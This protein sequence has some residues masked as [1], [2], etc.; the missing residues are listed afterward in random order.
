MIN[1]KRTLLLADDSENDLLLMRMA[2]KKVEADIALQEVHDG[3]EAIAYLQG[4]S[5][6]SDRNRFPL[7]TVMLMDLNMPKKNGFDVLT[8]V[9]A[10][11]GLKRLSIIVMTAST[12]TEDIER[13][14]E[15]GTNAFLVKP[16][17]LDALVT[18]LRCLWDWIRISRFA[19]LDA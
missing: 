14:F 5:P 1:E 4:A 13:A 8:W 3:E 2:F 15:L 9:R 6:Y 10:Q 18:M 12:R 7:P 17:N 11:P 16:G 19:P